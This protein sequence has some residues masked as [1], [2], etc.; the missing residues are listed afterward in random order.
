MGSDNIAENFRTT[1]D[2]AWPEP[3][4]EAER[5]DYYEATTVEPFQNMTRAQ[6][7]TMVITLRKEMEILN[8]ELKSKQIV[9]DIKTK[10]AERAKRAIDYMLDSAA[11]VTMVMEGE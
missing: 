5:F 1:S 9:I 6:F 2:W 11:L 3:P 4:Y 10:E 7:E 8:R